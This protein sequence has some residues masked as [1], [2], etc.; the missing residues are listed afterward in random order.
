MLKLTCKSRASCTTRCLMAPC[1]SKV[2][3]LTWDSFAYSEGFNSS[4]L[5]FP[6][7]ITP[8]SPAHAEVVQKEYVAAMDA[9]SANTPRQ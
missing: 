5:P 8:R 3:L 2:S 6:C 9:Y 4:P 7:S 1:L